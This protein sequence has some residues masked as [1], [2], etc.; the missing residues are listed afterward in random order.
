M[1]YIEHLTGLGN[2]A[3]ERII[4][5]LPLLLRLNPTAAPAAHLPV[6]ITEPSKSSVTRESPRATSRVTTP[7]RR[8]PDC[9]AYAFGAIARQTERAAFRGAP[10]LVQLNALGLGAVPATFYSEP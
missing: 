1:Q 6:P 7:S 10:A 3:E 4:A 5:A 9:F 8:G 2:R